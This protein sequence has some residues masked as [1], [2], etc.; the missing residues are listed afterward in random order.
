MIGGTRA[1]TSDKVNY[2]L[3]RTGVDLL[4]SGV[5]R[6]N[7][8]SAI[9]Q[10]VQSLYSQNKARLTWN[11]GDRVKGHLASIV[12]SATVKLYQLLLFTLPGT[13]IFNYGDEIGLMDDVSISDV[14]GFNRD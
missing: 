14:Y 11:F 5:L 6:D 7:S 10:T 3:N 4:L 13:P 12:D 9:A 2:L 8:A 1:N